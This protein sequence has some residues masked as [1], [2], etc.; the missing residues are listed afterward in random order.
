MSIGRDL[1]SLNDVAGL[2]E[3]RRR[4]GSGRWKKRPFLAQVLAR[5]AFW[6]G[7]SIPARRRAGGP[8]VAQESILQLERAWQAMEGQGFGKNYPG[9]SFFGYLTI[10]GWKLAG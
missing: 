4:V 8:V 9:F 3:R 2:V 1:R 7:F 6:E 10:K 5:D